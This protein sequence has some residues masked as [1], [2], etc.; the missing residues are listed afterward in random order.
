LK[1]SYSAYSKTK[2]GSCLGKWCLF[3]GPEQHLKAEALEHVREEARK[4]AREEPTWDLLDGKGLTANEVASRCQTGALFGGARVLVVREIERMEAGEQKKL[5]SAVGPL[6]PGVTVI[7]ITSGRQERGRERAVAAAL[8]RAA[9][10]NG[11]AVQ[12]SGFSVGEAVSWAV[13]RASRRG[14]KLEPAAAR[15]LVQQKVGTGLG[16]LES[17]IE[18]L[19]VFVGDLEI[20]AS[21]HVDE[22]TPRV[23]E[24]DIFRLTDAVGRREAGRPARAAGGEEGTALAGGLDAGPDHPADLADEAADG[25]RLAT[26]P[27]CRCGDGRPAA[28]GGGEERAGPVRAKILARREDSA[29][30]EGLLVGAAD[31]GNQGLE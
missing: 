17:E 8:R 26:G 24:E 6:P 25:A 14:K 22:V 20:I 10:R 2:K 15:K 4:A 21:A 11:L 12:F 30:G 31:A 16:E 18:K 3:S 9:E 1:L 19:A 23:V 5:A 29:A 27:G 13:E 7:L 28:A